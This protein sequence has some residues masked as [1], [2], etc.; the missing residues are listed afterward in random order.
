[1]ALLRDVQARVSFL[2]SADRQAAEIVEILR[3]T[4]RILAKL[5]A[6]VDR[7]DAQAPDDLEVYSKR[8]DRLEEAVLNIERATLGV[9]AALGAMPKALRTRMARERRAQTPPVRGGPGATL[10]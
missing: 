4:H 5:E 3:D 9:E 7:L 2:L 1:M 6:V 8:F 10:A